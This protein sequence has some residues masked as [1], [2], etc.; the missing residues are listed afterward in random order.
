M[1]PERLVSLFIDAINAAVVG[2]IYELM[3]EDH[4]FIDSDSKEVRGRDSMREGWIG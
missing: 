4:L 2:R 3:A 1:N